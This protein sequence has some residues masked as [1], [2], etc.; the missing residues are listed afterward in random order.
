MSLA[1]MK[2]GVPG[3]EKVGKNW[4]K[5]DINVDGQEWVV[6]RMM[7]PQNGKKR[8]FVILI[9]KCPSAFFLNKINKIW[10]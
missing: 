6:N 7:A 4:V 5:M 3:T 8:Y 2:M 1:L 9:F 10:E